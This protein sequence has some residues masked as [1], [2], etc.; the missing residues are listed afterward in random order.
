MNTINCKPYLL[1]S[2]LIRSESP[3][4]PFQQ[5]II[6]LFPAHPTL[7]SGNLPVVAYEGHLR[8]QAL[9]TTGLGF[10]VVYCCMSLLWSTFPVHLHQ[11]WGVKQ[12]V[13]GLIFTLVLLSHDIFLPIIFTFLEVKSSE[14]RGHI[15]VGLGLGLGSLSSRS[16]TPRPE[17]MLNP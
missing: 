5:R 14:A 7:L 11:V 13:V 4:R 1:Q 10:S 6:R 3:L 12:A 16:R 8:N 9:T 17:V 2:K 15:Q